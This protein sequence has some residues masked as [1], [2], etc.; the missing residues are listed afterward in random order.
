MCLRLSKRIRTIGFD[1]CP[2]IKGGK[3]TKVIGVLMSVVSLYYYYRIVVKMYLVD[4]DEADAG[5][6]LARDPWAAGVL[7]LCVAAIMVIGVF[8]APVVAWAQGGLAA[9]GLM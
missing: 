2:F 4:D 7:W 6:E 3:T 1:E 8:P 5:A 9:V